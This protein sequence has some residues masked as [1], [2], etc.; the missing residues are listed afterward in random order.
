MAKSS[1]L[2]FMKK[3]AAGVLMHITSLPSNFGIGD[4]GSEAREFALFLKDANQS[5]WQILPL[6]PVSASQGFSPYSSNSAM[7]LNTLLI[8]PDELVK[9]ALLSPRDLERFTV[10]SKNRV[11]FRNATAVKRKIIDIAYETFLS[12]RSTN[13]R[14][15]FNTFVKDENS[16]LHDFA[17]FTILKKTHRDKPWFE[18]PN[19]FKSRSSKA[20]EKFQIEYDEDIIKVKWEQFIV[21]QQWYGLKAFC[22]KLG[23][24]F[25]GDLPFYVGY[26]SADVWANQHVFNLTKGGQM[27]GVAGVPPDYFNADGQLWGMPVYQWDV[28][29]ND[30]YNWWAKRL[31]KNIQLFD[32]VRLD[33]FRAF[34][35]YWEVPANEETAKK[36]KWVKGPGE[37]FFKTVESELGELAFIAEDLGDINEAVISLRSNMKLPGMKILQFA[38]GGDMGKN[39]YLPHNYDRNFIVYTGTHDNNTTAGWFKNELQK[40]EKKNVRTYLNFDV[41]A[42]NIHEHL[43]RLAYSSVA[44]IAII[45]MQDVLGL[46]VTARMNVPASAKNNW[47]WQMDKQSL[48]SEAAFLRSMTMIYNRA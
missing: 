29:K 34:A 22:K 38:F 28:L 6:N 46:G 8:S 14:E 23:V 42:S 21:F 45:P 37:H 13:M 41:N 26:D 5:Y 10:S 11:D 19:P 2:G 25:I 33:H 32:V 15:R 3:R 43:T 12:M 20:L 27:K 40:T 18:W 35:D 30:K 47:A 44:Q 9:E 1:Q 31:K 17:L 4:L 36:G 48:H 39:D 7:A 24:S 16:W